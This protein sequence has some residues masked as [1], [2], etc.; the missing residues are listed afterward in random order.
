VSNDVVV[1]LVIV[2]LS[3]MGVS[4]L[5]WRLLLLLLLLQG[6][7]AAGN[8]EPPPY[9]STAV[10]VDLHAPVLEF[11]EQSP[12]RTFTNATELTLCVE[13]RDASSVAVSLRVQ[14]WRTVAP[15]PT[16]AA[17]LGCFTV[18]GVETTSQNCT[19]VASGTDDRVAPSVDVA[20]SARDGAFDCSVVAGVAELVCNAT[21]A[22]IVI[23][24]CDVGVAD[25]A[26]PCGVRW[27][28]E[29]VAP[30]VSVADG[31]CASDT[32]A[33]FS[34]WFATDLVPSGLSVLQP[35]VTVDALYRLAAVGVDEAGNVNTV[36]ARVSWRVDSV[37]PP[38]PVLL[39]APSGR[40]LAT[41]GVA[42][43]S[44]GLRCD[45]D[46]SPGTLRFVYS[47]TS[48]GSTVDGA[49]IDAQRN[50]SASAT[51]LVTLL[52]LHAGS[53][54]VLSVKSRDAVGHES[55][56]AA[57]ASWEV[58]STVPAVRVVARPADVSGLSTATFRFTAGYSSSPLATVAEARFEVLLKDDV[59]R[60]TWHSPCSER[61]AAAGC[62]AACNGTGCTYSTTLLAPKLYTL[63]VRVLLGG[64]VS[65]DVAT[66]SWEYRR[67]RSDQFAVFTN[68]SD[69]VTCSP[70]PAGGDCS[71]LFDGMIVTQSD[72]VARA[73]WWASASSDGRRFY[74]CASKSACLSPRA[75]VSDNATAN[76]TRAMCAPG[77]A[78]VLC[79]SCARGYFP[80]YKLCTPCP[81]KQSSAGVAVSVLLPLLLVVCFAGLFIARGMM[82]RG[83]GLAWCAATSLVIFRERVP[84]S[85]V[86]DRKRTQAVTLRRFGVCLCLQ[87]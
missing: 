72:I 21:A 69:A 71:P 79:S 78:G 81:A 26:A 54:Y 23:A 67:C 9:T 53:A 84:A 14:S 12:L 30:A 15:A 42:T 13:A 33:T 70:C 6:V 56:Y 19:V 65:D 47:L 57:V 80:K 3:G 11:P 8:V 37:A 62:A 49:V 77:Y 2:V 36:A 58:V 82:P 46:A 85:V 34:E 38:V 55:A 59:D 51:G 10:V 68:G 74:E 41:G 86:P 87:G 76:V 7:D 40:L 44:I 29:T 1:V 39:N 45:G 35:P 63:Q 61:G 73:G 50:G 75:A 22:A 83:T 17:G 4:L 64:G 43:V 5:S 32:S 25:A 16:S 18:S 60:G 52:D 24:A 48:G 20:L 66:I 28:L 27:R 31:S